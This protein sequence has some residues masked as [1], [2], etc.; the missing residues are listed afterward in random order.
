MLLAPDFQKEMLAFKDRSVRFRQKTKTVAYCKI[1]AFQLPET[2][3][4]I[5]PDYILNGRPF[6]ND[7]LFAIYY[8]FH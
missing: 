3:W 7:N 6:K 4:G 5:C 8:Y 2:V 1:T